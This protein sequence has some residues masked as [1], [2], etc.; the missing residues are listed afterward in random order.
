MNAPMRKPIDT[1]PIGRL[2]AQRLIEK[3]IDRLEVMWRQLQD[4]D[5]RAVNHQWLKVVVTVKELGLNVV[6]LRE[7]TLAIEGD[8]R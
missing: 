8:Q 6:H 7:Q 5:D 4:E 3:A 1:R 2:E